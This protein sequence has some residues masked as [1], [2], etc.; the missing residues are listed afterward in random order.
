MLHRSGLQIVASAAGVLLA[1]A[2]DAH[3]MGTQGSAFASGLAHPFAGLDHVLAV[4]AIGVWA[5]Q[6]GGRA[7][8]AV[9]LS[10]VATMLL[11]AAL[12]IAGIPL[13]SVEPAIAVSLMILGLLVTLSIRMRLVTGMAVAAGFALFHGH[14][15]GA[16]IAAVSIAQY[17]LGM[18]VAT[19][20]LHA[21]GILFGSLPK[22]G[23]GAKVLR[24]GGAAIAATGAWMLVGP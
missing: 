3:S 19:V 11:G 9:P 14:A 6:N 13:P 22:A 8:W 1:Q 23:F 18:T 7:L 21:A 20:L 17:L 15:H 10:F 4:V 2:A 5:A 16:E 12:G 24:F